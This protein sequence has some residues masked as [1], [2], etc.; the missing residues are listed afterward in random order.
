MASEDEAATVK[1]G[2]ILK[3]TDD[4]T[5]KEEGFSIKQIG[6]AVYIEAKTD[7]GLLY[8][9]FD[10]ICRIAQGQS[11]R[12]L[13]ITENPKNNFRMLNHWDNM[14]GKYRKRLFR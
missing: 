7:K 14:D 10:L 4:F 12:G 11:I 1:S 8:G 3:L 5:L 6:E 13:N 2:I 9:S